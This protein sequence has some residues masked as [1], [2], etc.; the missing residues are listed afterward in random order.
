MKQFIVTILFLST[1]ISNSYSQVDY[2]IR[3]AMDL[4]STNK[5]RSGD[6]KNEQPESDI[7]GSP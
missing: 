2:E 5:F 4:Y 6:S 1:L 7:K 3:Q